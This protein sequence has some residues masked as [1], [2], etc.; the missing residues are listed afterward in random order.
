MKAGERISNPVAIT[1]PEV[2]QGRRRNSLGRAVS[3]G[4]QSMEGGLVIGTI[5][6]DLLDSFRDFEVRVAGRRVD[7]A[8]AEPE[9]DGEA[10][11]KPASFFYT[12]AA[13][14]EIVNHHWSGDRLDLDIL[15]SLVQP[16]D[17]APA[18]HRR[19]RR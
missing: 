9:P 3:E 6:F 7:P 4:I 11:Q 14:T 2:A 19:G 10:T 17:H 16:L 5:L 13:P 12:D 18:A 1:W 15:A 8:R